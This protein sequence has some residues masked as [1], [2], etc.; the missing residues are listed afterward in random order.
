MNQH[1]RQDTG[2]VYQLPFHEL[3]CSWFLL[4]LAFFFPK[5]LASVPI[6]FELRNFCFFADCVT[7]A[8][9]FEDL[10]L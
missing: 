8:V 3:V 6:V 5:I 9:V 2:C 1:I 10:V 7:V 4:L